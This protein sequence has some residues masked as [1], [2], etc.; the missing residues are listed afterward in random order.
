MHRPLLALIPILVL[1]GASR[2]GEADAKKELKKL[3]GTW[4]VILSEVNGTTMPK[5]AFKKVLVEIKDDRVIFKDNGKVYEEA[6]LKLDPKADPKEIDYKYVV[7]LKKGVKELGIYR[8]Q[9]E[10]LTICMAQGRQKRPTE[11]A[12]KKGI[13]DQLLTLKRV[14]P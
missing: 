3:Q 9:G 11:F 6:E 5:Q 8:L 4:K 14:T 7:G 12:S 2:A 13:G 10:Q 1:L